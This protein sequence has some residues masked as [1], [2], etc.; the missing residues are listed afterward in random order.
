M[1]IFYI[2]AGSFLA[3]VSIAILVI[4]C[5]PSA[6]VVDFYRRFFTRH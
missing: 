2:V 3:I 6:T 5:L 1:L 4:S